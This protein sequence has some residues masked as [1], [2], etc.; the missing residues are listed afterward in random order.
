MIKREFDLPVVDV[1]YAGI[2]K[3][4]LK[5][6]DNNDICPK[7]KGHCVF[8]D[9]NGT[10]IECLD[11]LGTGRKKASNR[12]RAQQSGITWFQYQRDGWDKV[13][14]WTLGKCRDALIEAEKRYA[15]AL[16]TT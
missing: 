7:C 6:L 1:R 5:E 3:A 9:A 15:A 13:Y 10:E 4:V 11:C 16:A 14:E 8:T 12:W 2:R